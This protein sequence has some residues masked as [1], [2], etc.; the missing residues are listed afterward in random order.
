MFQLF[1]QNVCS[2]LQ[3]TLCVV[4]I[5]CMKFQARRFMISAYLPAAKKLRILFIQARNYAPS[6]LSPMKIFPVLIS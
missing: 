2:R 6:K 4:L 5:D 3:C 1:I